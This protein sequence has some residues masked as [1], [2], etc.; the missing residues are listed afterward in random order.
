MRAPTEI[1]PLSV[2]RQP[3]AIL[4]PLKSIVIGNR[5]GAMD[6]PGRPRSVD[7]RMDARHDNLLVAHPS[8]QRAALNENDPNASLG[9]WR[10]ATGC[11]VHPNARAI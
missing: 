11:E 4:N 9:S 7:G 2:A 3:D 8:K 6:A 5:K 1:T 10:S